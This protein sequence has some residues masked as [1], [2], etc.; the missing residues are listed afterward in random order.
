MTSGKRNQECT[1]MLEGERGLDSR[2]RLVNMNR[3]LLDPSLIRC[4]PPPTPSQPGHPTKWARLI[5]GE[6]VKVA[7]SDGDKASLEG[8]E[9]SM[10]YSGILLTSE[11]H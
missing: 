2:E 6:A 9:K 1:H 7:T 11:S 5:E 10:Q 4:T 3:S 8:F